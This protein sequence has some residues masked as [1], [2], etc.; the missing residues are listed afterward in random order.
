MKDVLFTKVLLYCDGPQIVE[1]QDDIGGSYIA[2]LVDDCDGFDRYLICGIH[3]RK[4]RNFRVGNTDLRS[5]LVESSTPEWGLVTVND[6]ARDL[7]M[8]PEARTGPIDAAFLPDEG[9]FLHETHAITDE[10]LVKAHERNNLVLEVIVEPPESASEHRIH[11]ETLAGLL[12]NIQTLIKHSYRRVVR[13][14]PSD[15]RALI[16]TQDGYRMDVFVPAVAGSF[17][18]WLES[19]DSHVALSN[20]DLF[21][22]SPLHKALDIVDTF[23]SHR[24]DASETIELARTYKGHLSGSYLRLLKFLKKNNT[25]LSYRWATPLSNTSKSGSLS[26]NRV[27]DLL[28]ALSGMSD[29]GTEEVELRGTVDKADSTGKSWRIRD[30]STTYSGS[31]KDDGPDLEGIVIGEHYLFKCLERIEAI[32]GTGKEQR[33]LFLIER[34]KLDQGASE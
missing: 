15:L 26:I 22:E 27:V 7:P 1:A 33:S 2:L 8:R 23:V 16:D 32:E 31:V 25:G 3:P 4:L 21:S 14:L 30:G 6:N 17:G 9:F 29:L 12:I 28:T 18:I 13:D 11:A 34:E 20:T 5:I 24:D 19:C 10:A